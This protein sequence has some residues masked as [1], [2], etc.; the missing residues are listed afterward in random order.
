MLSAKFG[1]I[2]GSKNV[3]DTKGKRICGVKG[4]SSEHINQICFGISK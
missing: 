1:G 4:K 3:I 2:G